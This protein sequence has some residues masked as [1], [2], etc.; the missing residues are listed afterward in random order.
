MKKYFTLIAV[1]IFS[2]PNVLATADVYIDGLYYNLDTEN[3]TAEVTWEPAC[4]SSPNNYRNLSKD[5]IIPSS[6]KSS[7]VKYKVKSIGTYAFCQCQ[8]IVYVTIPSSVTSIG[9]RAFSGC[10]SLVD[11]NIPNSVTSIGV[12]AFW[13]CESL[14]SVFIP[15]SVT[16]IGDF[17]FEIG[18]LKEVHI[19]NI[20]AWCAIDF[21]GSSGNPLYYAGHLYLNDIEIEDLVIP[22][23]VRSINS[24]AFYYCPGITSITIPSSVVSIGKEAFRNA[25]GLTSIT[26]P[27]NVK[28]IGENA[29]FGCSNIENIYCESATPAII[30]ENSFPAV[31]IYVPNCAYTAYRN[32]PVWK[33]LTI[34]PVDVNLAVVNNVGGV[35]NETCGSMEIEAIPYIGY[36]FKRWQDGNKDNPRKYTLTQ[37]NR[38]F[39]AEFELDKHQI[40]LDFEA[41]HGSIIGDNGKFNYGTEHTIEAVPN[42]GYHF[43]QWSDG[44]TENPRTF[45]L[46][47]DTTFTAEFAPNEY[48][49]TIQCDKAY[50]EVEAE[51]G[52]FDYLSEHT[53]EANANYGYHFSSWSDGVTD[54]PRTLILTKDTTLI[55]TFAPNKYQLELIADATM[56]AIEGEQGEFDYLS[57]KTF[58]AVPNNGYQFTGWS[59]GVTDNPR[60]ITLTCDTTFTALF[61]YNMHEV[62]VLCNPEQGSVE[63]SGE[64]YHTAECTISAT[65]NYGYHFVQWNDGETDNP[66]TFVVTQDTTFTAEFAKNVYKI[67]KIAD[68][69]QGRIEGPSEA[70]YLTEVSLEAIPNEYRQFVQWSD[71]NTDNPRTII[72]TQDTAFTA[73][74]DLIHY[75]VIFL[76]YNGAVLSE[77]SVAY[78]SSATAPE[79]AEREGYRFIGWSADIEH[80]T[81]CTF[82]IALYEKKGINITYKGTEGEIIASEEVDIHI[83]DAPIIEGSTFAGW[84]TEAANNEDGI[85]LRATYSLDHPTV[86]EDVTIEPGS[87]TAG[88]SFPYITGTLTY[89]LV[90]RDLFGFVVCKIMF[91][92]TGHLLGVAFA[93]GHKSAQQAQTEGFQFTVEGLTPST[94]YE[95]EFVAHDETDA[96]I[97]KLAGSFTTTED[98]TTEMANPNQSNAPQKIMYKGIMYILMHNGTIYN[99]QGAKVE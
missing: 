15:Q 82:A 2:I 34:V 51:Q 70:E 47:Q 23:G 45:V 57:E 21:E 46:E 99:A 48:E 79:V 90:V 98:V 25:T 86:N 11:I 35:V 16:A 10:N 62:T 22:D 78:N 31:P 89:V 92:A 14:T 4:Q 3:E 59:D 75:P 28:T 36:H 42:Y 55:A 53:I 68:A 56:G 40:T 17:A 88:V 87:T 7:G 83:P 30:F 97:E 84:L 33:D 24:Y 20:A 94:T 44:E 67:E 52:K 58:E 5:L 27:S 85:I 95:Y 1:L 69:E 64:T 81:G 66:R 39:I 96:V 43:T 65:P 6:I 50:G 72:L 54:N 29:F 60:T 63:K 71:G 18:G 13:G 76:D 49:L 32:A 37:S 91:N 38:N 26:I 41:N 93:P 8:K 73:Q 9:V 80:I 12:S 19:S 61:E 77:Q 74:F